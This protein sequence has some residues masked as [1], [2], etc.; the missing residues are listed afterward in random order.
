MS[1]ETFATAIFLITAVLAAAILVNAFFPIIYS[2]TNTFTSSSHTADQNLRTDIKII[3]T[4]SNSA[5]NPNAK[6]WIKNVGSA[7][8]ADVDLN[9]SDIFIGEPGDFE[10]AVLK[11][12][13]ET[14]NDGE[15]RYTI[16][17]TS[18]DDGYW[19]PAETLLIEVM[20]NKI[21]S[22]GDAYFQ[23]VL[24]SGIMRSQI[25]SPSG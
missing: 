2:A 13:N 12:E 24:P 4:F 6:I 14:L 15:W 9:R 11:E 3:N 21:Q 16:L 25:F 8:I 18:D 17:P 10:M 7:R 20:S 1:S 5:Q 23:I 19:D 22:E